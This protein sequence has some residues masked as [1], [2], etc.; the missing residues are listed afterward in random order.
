MLTSMNCKFIWSTIRSKVQSQWSVK[1]WWPEKKYDSLWDQH[2]RLEISLWEK[3]KKRS[4]LEIV[5][6]IEPNTLYTYLWWGRYQG[7]EIAPDYWTSP[8]SAARLDPAESV[9]D[10]NGHAVWHVQINDYLIHCSSFRGLRRIFRAVSLTALPSSHKWQKF[11]AVDE[12]FR[13]R[14]ANSG[15]VPGSLAH[16][17]TNKILISCGICDGLSVNAQIHSP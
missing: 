4:F 17:K 3:L 9:R 11:F 7:E 13:S 1:P 12:A 6:V 15:L 10:V 14:R 5:Q 16:F 8:T 2:N